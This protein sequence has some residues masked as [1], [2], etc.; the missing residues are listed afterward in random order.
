MD[1]KHTFLLFAM[2]SFFA[3]HEASAQFGIRAGLT[4]SS[5]DDAIDFVND[6]A[7]VTADIRGGKIGWTAGV[8]FRL[9]LVAIYIQPELLLTHNKYIYEVDDDLFEEGHLSLDVPAL[10]G[11][12]LG[13]LRINAGPEAHVHVNKTSD[14]VDFDF[15]KNSVKTFTLGWLGGAGLDLMGLMLDVRYHGSLNKVGSGV[16]IGGEEIE[17]DKRPGQWSFT[18]GFRF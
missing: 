11:I 14:L 13:P 6:G 3:I 1:M 4:S 8:M 7:N 16:E 2:L 17:F 18:V 15:Y 9:N 10:V 5:M 12:K